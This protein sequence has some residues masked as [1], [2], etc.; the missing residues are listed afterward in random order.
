M[1]HS[2]DKPKKKK[3]LAVEDN[4]ETAGFLRELL[5]D[6][7]DLTIVGTGKDALKEIRSAEQDA[8]VIILNH[9]LPD[10]PG[11]EVL[12]EMKA[13]RPGIP[14]IFTTPYG[15]E[16]LAVKAFR[17]GARDYLKIPFNYQQLLH[18][19]EFV[20]SLPLQDDHRPRSLASAE[21]DHAGQN[22]PAG[23]IRPATK[24]NL[25]KALMYIERNYMTRLSLDTVAKK[26]CTSKH[27]LSRE[28]RKHTG[29]TY[30]EYLNRLRTDKAR[31]L[32]SG[33]GASVTTAAFAVGFTDLR[34]FQRIFKKLHG[35]SPRQY[36]DRHV[37][38]TPSPDSV[39]RRS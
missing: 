14:V 34:N 3:V 8:A 38:K 35:C 15:S 24:H 9:R 25:E 36:R 22:G 20:L 27:H 23:E 32:L 29:C 16:D 2:T 30:R 5:S 18:S 11:L 1:K 31:E 12:R 21:A 33:T 19:I 37:R 17:N 4:P 39:R 7:Y 13:A 28:F 6:L 26:A 10:R